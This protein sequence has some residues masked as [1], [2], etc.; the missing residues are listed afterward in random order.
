MR[1]G[2]IARRLV[3]ATAIAVMLVSGARQAQ[4]KGD[5]P[6]LAV[7]GGTGHVFVASETANTIG[8]I[9]ASSG[10]ILRTVAVG[11][12]PFAF[13]VD[14]RTS[15]LF[16]LTTTGPS[17]YVAVLDT[18]S[19]AILRKEPT[20]ASPQTLAVDEE[21][22]RVFALSSMATVQVLDARTGAVVR[23]GTTHLAVYTAVVAPRSRRVFL[24]GADNG[25]VV[26]VLD[27]R[28]GALLQTIGGPTGTAQA[29]VGGGPMAVD[30]R[31]GRVFALGDRGVS[32]LDVNSG[33]V[34]RTV[35]VGPSPWAVAADA[36]AGHVFVST[37]SGIVML[38]AHTGAVLRTAASA[39][40]FLQLVVDETT[41]HAFALGQGGRL[42]MLDARSG[43]VARTLTGV[44][45]DALAVD[46]R[47]GRVF[48]RDPGG[49]QV[50]NAVTGA[51][52]RTI[53]VGS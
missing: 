20:M 44:G 8:M 19:G 24:G 25:G 41:Q 16:V 36:R 43:R 51:R 37:G 47:R 26:A 22:N 42:V 18:R 9:D 14:A 5:E 10:R 40:A 29:D 32:V 52:L 46:E 15:R 4:A 23:N 34:L 49:I 50:L 3:A 2:Q 45:G 35:A 39:T 11:G 6:R 31:T 13:A 27:A 21:T 12:P 17:G 48:V 30:D 7:D 33:R 53:V 1:R 28:S 38:D